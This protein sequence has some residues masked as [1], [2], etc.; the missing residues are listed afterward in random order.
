M[1]CEISK[2]KEIVERSFELVDKDEKGTV[3][4]DL[5]IR[6]MSRFMELKE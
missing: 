6:L 3:E 2:A 5:V 1:E 4:T